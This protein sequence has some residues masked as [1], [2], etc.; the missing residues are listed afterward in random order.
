MT[1]KREIRKREILEQGLDVLYRNGYAATG[2]QE[3]ADAS[4]IPKGSFYN[5]FESKEHFAV[6]AV[7]LYSRRLLAVEYLALQ[8]DDSPEP[9]RKTGGTGAEMNA[10]KAVSQSAAKEYFSP[11]AGTPPAERVALFFQRLAE[12]HERRGQPGPGCLVGNLSQELGGHSD[13]LAAAINE[14]FDDFR[15]PIVSCLRAAAAG[16]PGAK[17]AAMDPDLLA[18]LIV[19]GYQGALVRMKAQRSAAPLFE[20]HRCLRALLR[21]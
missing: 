19:N 21:V 15:R 5:Y 7:G 18:G 2:V 6:E 20:F 11:P 10:P 16:G 8:A 3:L 14:F 17:P 12:H 4:G 1:T 13:S 9:E